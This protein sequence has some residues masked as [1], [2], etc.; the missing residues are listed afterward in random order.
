MKVKDIMVIDVR[1]LSPESSAKDAFYKILNQ[2]ISGLPVIDENGKLVGMF[3]EKDILNYIL[4]SYI[5]KV[6]KFIYG[7]TPKA[8]MNKLITLDQ[9]KVKDLMRKEVVTINEDAPLAEAAHLVLTQKARRIPVVKE[10][11]V[12]GIIA[13]EDI[14]RAFARESGLLKRERE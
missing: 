1:H 10:S 13:R 8:I 12:I 11:K 14:L 5:E 9:I 3:T 6:G 2:H 7:E 4:P